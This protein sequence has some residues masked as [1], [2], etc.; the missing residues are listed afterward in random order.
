MTSTAQ[1]AHIPIILAAENVVR[2]GAVGS[3]AVA[4]AAGGRAV[5][6]LAVARLRGWRSRLRAGQESRV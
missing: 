6:R 1:R 4:R 2:R 3:R 5:A